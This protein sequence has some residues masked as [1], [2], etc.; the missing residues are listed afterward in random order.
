MRDIADDFNPEWHD[1]VTG[2]PFEGSPWPDVCGYQ[3]DEQWDGWMCG[4]G[5]AEH[6][7]QERA[8]AGS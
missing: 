8:E 6:A 7:T 4:Y 5:V 2:H 1:L 3:L